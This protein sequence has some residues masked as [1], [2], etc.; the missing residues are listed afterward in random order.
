MFK[1]FGIVFTHQT[2]Q[3]QMPLRTVTK[4]TSNSSTQLHNTKE[5]RQYKILSEFLFG[6]HDTLMRAE[7]LCRIA[8]SEL[9]KS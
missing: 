2:E 5:V 9:T 7:L 1:G 8:E 4:A 3:T 6:S